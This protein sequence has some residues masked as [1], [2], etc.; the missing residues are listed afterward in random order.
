M[1]KSTV[2]F[3]KVQV[4]YLMKKTGCKDPNEAVEIYSAIIEQEGVDP[5]KMVAYLSL[6]MERDKSK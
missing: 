2:Y 5:H 1:S 6:I 3:S 4:E